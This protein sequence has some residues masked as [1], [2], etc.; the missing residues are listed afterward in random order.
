METRRKAPVWQR[1]VGGL[2][3][4]AHMAL[5]VLV[6][7]RGKSKPLEHTSQHS[8]SMQPVWDIFCTHHTDRSSSKQDAVQDT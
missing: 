6:V 2:L 7:M 3:G 5:L 8:N 4:I 1:I